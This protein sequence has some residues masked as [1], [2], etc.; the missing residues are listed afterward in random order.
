MVLGSNDISF[1]LK[2]EMEG[3]VMNLIHVGMS[4]VLPIIH[5][6]THTYIYIRKLKGYKIFCCSKTLSLQNK[7]RKQREVIH[8][9]A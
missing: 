1:H 7:N 4:Y 6:D 9:I 3:E 5:T 2:E 8:G